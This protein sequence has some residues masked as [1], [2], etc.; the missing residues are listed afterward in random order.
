MVTME[1]YLYSNKSGGSF[2]VKYRSE[3][4]VI[5]DVMKVLFCFYCTNVIQ[6]QSLY[7]KWSICA[8]SEAFH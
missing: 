5:K 1:V 3:Q 4:V 8:L 2:C 6:K 7:I